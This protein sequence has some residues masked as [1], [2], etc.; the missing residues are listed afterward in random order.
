[1]VE[2]QSPGATDAAVN[3]RDTEQ[4]RKDKRMASKTQQ[5]ANPSVL[6]HCFVWVC[7]GL[8]A[9]KAASSA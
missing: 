7:G 6:A 8:A 2:S 9:R 5:A 3:D 1:M 4:G